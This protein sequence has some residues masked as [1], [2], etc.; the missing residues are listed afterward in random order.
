MS[1]SGEESPVSF[2]LDNE[3]L[4]VRDEAGGGEMTL[5]VDDVASTTPA[6]GA[7]FDVPVDHAV[8][9]EASTVEIP[10]A[11]SA[12][13][14][15]DDGEH[16]GAV[17]DE[18]FTV[19]GGTYVDLDGALKLLLY[20]EEGPM[21]GGLV[22]P[23][24]NP[25]SLRLSF[26]NPTHVV[27]GARSPHEAPVATMTIRD[28]PNDLM[29]AV[30]Y[31]GS[32]IKEWSAER[33]WP[34]LR[35]HPPAIEIGDEL[36]IPDRLSRPDTEVSVAVPR[37]TGDVLRVAPLAHY[38]GADVVPGDRAELRLGSQHA[39]PLGSGAS[40]EQSVDELLGHAIVLDSLVRIDGYYSL[41]RYEYDE[42]AP[43]L[44]FYPPELYDQPVHRQLLEYLEVS[45]ETV[46]PY[47]PTWPAVG[48]LRPTVADAEAVPYLL[49]RLLRVHVTD[50]GLP[51]EPSTLAKPVDLASATEVPRGVAAFP[52]EARERAARHE[53][54]PAGEASLL[55]VGES[56]PNTESFDAVDWDRF[57]LGGAP[58]IDARR[59]VTREELRS[60]LAEPYAYVHY[61]DRVSEAGFVCSDGVLRFDD[62]PEG[63][64]GAISFEWPRAST[65]PL[66]AIHDVASVACLFPEPVDAGTLEQ[67]GVYL[68]VGRSVAT[69]ASLAGVDD[70]RCLGD[71][72]LTVTRRPTGHAPLIYHV[73]EQRPGE[74]S[75]SIQLDT[76]RPDMLGQITGSRFDSSQDRFQLGGTREHVDGTVS[77]AELADFLAGDTILQFDWDSESTDPSTPPELDDLRSK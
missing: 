31:L 67:F 10:Q 45:Y 62:L 24:H 12:A 5:A 32:S 46:A 33:S 37:D 29:T 17:T 66:V 61:G 34:T 69:S 3:V 9:L 15:S 40:L 36:A 60:L 70:A 25:E 53:R 16:Y 30:S 13:I 14:R 19:G 73:A 27:V 4:T 56:A 52:P 55:F 72:T 28:D 2:S 23:T 49:D 75:V 68:A 1:E 63:S 38:F 26:E 71:A 48:T 51:R 42:L 43:E 74:Y 59:S 44:P 22:G 58:T 20:V 76:E 8:S 39:E 64:V 11:T 50:D 47:V 57:D 41:P 35:G 65:A 18:E 7:W 6:T 54:R 21:E 77:E